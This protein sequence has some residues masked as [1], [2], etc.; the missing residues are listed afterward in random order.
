MKLSFHGGAGEVSGACYLLKT[1]K[2]KALVD[3]GLFQGCS[4][5]DDSNFKPFGFDASSIDAVLVTHAHVDHIGRI[6]KLVREGFRGKIFSTPPTRDLAA[7]L[8]EDTLRLSERRNHHNTP[9]SERDLAKTM[10]QW[11]TV[12]YEKKFRIDD[13]EVAFRN[14]GHILGSSLIALTAEKKQLLFT[15]DLGN[16]PS[17]LLPPPAAVRDAEYLIIESTYGN[18]THETPEERVL[19]LERA[20]EDTVAR[21][22]TLLIPA[23]A[24]ERTQDLLHLLNEMVHFKRIPELPVFVDSPLA[25]EA[26][27]VFEKYPDYYQESIRALFHKHPNLFK[28]KK[29]KFTETVDQS[30][31]INTVPPPKVII[32]GSGT[33]RGGRI[34]HHMVRYLPDPKS[35]VLLVGYQSAGSAGRRLLDGEKFITMLGQEVAVNA[36]IRKIGGFSA[37]ADNPQLFSFVSGTRDTLKRVFVVQGEWAEAAHFVQEIRDRLGVD[38]VAPR[39]GE[40]F[41][42]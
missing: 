17:I 13:F 20:V 9:W 12:P 7:L 8:L 16:T 32:A 2:S 42:L 14:A 31:F 30:K 40:V 11:E 37:H 34:L 24:T 39:L 3:C 38:A 27:K 10:R 4:E 21:G 28:F 6:P 41:E 26:T 25:I 5:C 35:I 29:L 33:M 36:E 23:F 15:G 1:R 19:K 22:G 18:R